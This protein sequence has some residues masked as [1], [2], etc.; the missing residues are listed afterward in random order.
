M[1]YI[2]LF[3]GAGGLSEGLVKIGFHPITHV[4]I[5]SD[6]AYTLKT[7]ACYYYLKH[8]NML[9]IY[10]EYMNNTISR[11]KLYSYV[12]DTILLKL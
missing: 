8:N 4:E 7:R 12:P 3:A 6:V 10:Y 5:N 1:N 2:D 11:E 9:N